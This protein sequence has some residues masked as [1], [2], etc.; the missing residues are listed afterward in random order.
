M[1]TLTIEQTKYIGG[2]SVTGVVVY[3]TLGFW[4]GCFGGLCIG[5]LPAIPGSLL[6]LTVGIWM[7]TD[8]QPQYIIVTESELQNFEG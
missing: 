8:S 4:I 3:G 6:G 7:G 1:K 2:G 5:V